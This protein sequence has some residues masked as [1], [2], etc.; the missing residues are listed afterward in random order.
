MAKDNRQSRKDISPEDKQRRI[1]TKGIREILGI[2]RYALPYKWSFIIG[3]IFL[4]L[5]TLSTL[6][7]PYFFGLLI[8][9]AV[10]GYRVSGNF[11]SSVPERMV[12]TPFF[13]LQGQNSI[14][15]VAIYLVALLVFQAIFSYFRI[16]LFANV[17]ERTMA[18]IREA[19]YA[20]IIT[21]PIVFF[22]QRRVGEL[23]GRIASDVTQLQD[24]LYYVLAELLRQ[25]LTLVIGIAIL[26]T[27]VSSKLTLFMLLTFPILVIAALFFGRFI[28]TLSKKA[29]DNLADTNTIVDETFQSITVVK[30][31][32]NEWLEVSRYNKA[33]RKV[34][35]TA[36]QAVIYRGVFVS[37][38]IVALFGG[39]ILVIWRGAHMIQS[40][41]IQ[42]GELISF[43][44][45]TAFIGG[46]VAGMGE[47]YSQIQKTL[48]ASERIREILG[49]KSEIE[50]VPHSAMQAKRVEGDILLQD[51]HFSYPSRK[52]ISVLKG[53][54]MHIQPGQK[55]ALVGPSGSGK[56]TITRLLYRFY[57]VQSGNILLDGKPLSD[58]DLNEL[59]RNM[60]VVPQ[61][62]I[63]FGGTIRENISY[64]KPGAEENEIIQAAI[65]AN[66]WEFVSNFPEGLDTI[67]G[68]RGIKLSGGQRQRIAIARAILKDPAILILDEATS[69][70]DAESELLVQ[71]ALNRLM[72]GRTTLVI[73]HRLSTIRQVDKIYVLDEGKIL[74]SGT[75]LELAGQE[76]GLYSHLLRLQFHPN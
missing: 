31:F 3:N 52:D 74:E 53:I 44:F 26:F 59:R 40:G 76:D 55:V 7:L 15:S 61:E 17:S 4:L 46:S 69:S 75:H 21:L 68:E 71:S 2:F 45:Y 62:V 32:S 54:S 37:F 14:N 16:Y 57:E 43:M 22:E 70:L 39:I 56:S 66:A 18:D 30:G 49:E 73:A 50:P 42:V 64:G 67:V 5:S 10:P 12:P 19:L 63:L 28:R 34:V 48:G 9:V 23:T 60:G 11:P 36:M 33:L 25:I 58:Y 47:M 20:K 27:M 51:V 24:V 65:Q 35:Q 38:I 6:L 41:E 13:S 72:E 1:T 29:Q 8:D